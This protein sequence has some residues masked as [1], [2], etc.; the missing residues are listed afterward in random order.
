MEKVI[1]LSETE[2]E[3]F[4][5]EKSYTVSFKMNKQIRKW[6]DEK[7]ENFSDLIRKSLHEQ[8]EYITERDLLTLDKLKGNQV[9]SV[10]LKESELQ[11]LDE[12]AKKLGITRTD[13]ILIKM[14][15][16]IANAIH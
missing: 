8:I 1:K 14:G 7:C 15:R 12:D 4:F 5:D 13:L 10:R 2:Y 9:V 3:I 11:K 16:V 6:L